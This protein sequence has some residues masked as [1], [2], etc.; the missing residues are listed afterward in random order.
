M[1]SMRLATPSAISLVVGRP[2]RN[3]SLGNRAAR[4]GT[5]PTFVPLFRLRFL[6]NPS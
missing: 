1:L 3:L 2:I 6:I 4:P 5:L